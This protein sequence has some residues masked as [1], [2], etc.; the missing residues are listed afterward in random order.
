MGLFD[1]IT[2]NDLRRIA[3]LVAPIIKSD[4]IQVN[5]LPVAESIDGLYTLPAVEQKGGIIR[6]V[7]APVSLL[8]GKN[9]DKGDSLEFVILGNYP[10][11]S[12]L[13]S[14]YPNGPDRNGL[15]KVGDT[16]YT[17]TGDK[18]EPLNIDVLRTFSLE[19]F[20]EVLPVDGHI[21]IDHAKTPYAKVTL[22]G[23]N[24]IF[25]LSVNNTKDG[26]TGK[27]LVFQTGFKQISLPEGIRGTVDLPL[28]ADTIALLTYN[29]LGDT[30]YIHSNTVLGDVQFPTPQRIEDFQ[31]VYYDNSVCVLQWSAPWANNI[32]DKAT[33][34][35]MRYSNTP[36]DADDPIVWAGMKKVTGLP[37]P[38]SYPQ[39]QR[40][41]LT[42]LDAGNEYY[43]YL[44]SIKVNY[45]IRYT[46]VASDPA[47]CRTRGVDADE[48]GYYRID[49]DARMLSPRTHDT[50][51]DGSGNP[52]LI[53]NAVDEKGKD[54]FLYTGYPD[55][56]NRSYSTKW[57]LQF[58]NNFNPYRLVIDLHVPCLLDK[59]YL[60]AIGGS[61]GTFRIFVAPEIGE[62]AEYAATVDSQHNRCAVAD[63]S[64]KTGR[65]ILLQYDNDYF[66]INQDDVTEGGEFIPTQAIGNNIGFISRLMVYG[67][68]TTDK[69]A[70]LLPPVRHRLERRTVDDFFNVVGWFY[71]QGR[72]MSLC[73]GKHV[74]LFGSIGHFLPNLT[75]NPV[76]RVADVAIRANQVPWVSG[77]NGT[78]ENFIPHLHHTYERYGLKPFIA[79][80]GWPDMLFYKNADGSRQSVKPLDAYWLP[81]SWRPLPSKGLRGYERYFAQTMNPDNYKTVTKLYH[82]LAA[83]FGHGQSDLSDLKIFP[84]NDPEVSVNLDLLSG[85]EP[86][87]EEDG[88]WKGWLT[89]AQPQELAAWL[90]AVYDGH[91]GTIMD[92]EGNPIPGI[93]GVSPQTLVIV[94]GMAQINPGYFKEMYLWA[95]ENRPDGKFPAD[96][97]NVHTYFSDK[98]KPGHLVQDPCKAVT[99]EEILTWKGAMGDGLSQIVDFRNR[100]L[101]DLEIWITEFGY[102]ESGGEN[103]QSQYQCY[104]Q[105][106]RYIGS[107]L[108]PDRH[109]S[110]V[111]GAWIL[112]AALTMMRMGIGSCNCYAIEMDSYFGNGQY[113]GGAGFEMFRWNDCTDQAPG[114]KVEAIKKYMHGYDRGGFATTGIFNSLLWCGGYPITRS[115]WYIATFRNRLKGYVY[116][117]Q[118]Y[119]DTDSRIIVMCFRKKG[120]DKGAYVIYLNDDQNTGVPNVKV[121]LPD[122]SSSVTRVTTYCPEIPNPEN[123][124]ANLEFDEPRTGFPTTRRERYVNGK[125]VIQ[126]SK[127]GNTYESFAQGPADYP[128]NPQEGDEVYVLPTPEENPYFPICGP[129]GANVTKH[130]LKPSAQEYEW[131][132]PADPELPNGEPKWGM[133]GN[134][135]LAWRQVNAVCDYIEYTGE[136]R[137]GTSG[138][139]TVMELTGNA[140]IDNVTEFPA[141]YFFD[142]I[143]EPDYRSRVTDVKAVTI[144]A[145]TVK[146]FWNNGNGEDTAYEI[147]SSKSES[148]GYSLLKTV[149][150]G[151][152]NVAVLSGLDADTGYYFKIRAVSGSRQGALSDSA[153]ARTYPLIATPENLRSE[154]RTATTITLSWDY[155]AGA[156]AD[157]VMFALYRSG[158]DGSYTLVGK[159]EDLAARVFT[160]TGLLPGVSYTY[161]MRV[162]ALNGTSE[163]TPELLVTTLTAEQSAPVVSDIHTD[164]LG[165][166]IT[167]T[168]DLPM[169]AADASVKDAFTLSE[170][171]APRLVRNLLSDPE[172]PKNIILYINQD[173]LSDYDR[174][175]DIRLSYARPDT[176]ALT[177]IYGVALEPFSLRVANNIG[178]FTNLQAT[179][180]LNLCDSNSPAPLDEYWNNFIAVISENTSP[181]RDKMP[182]LKDTY[183]RTLPVAVESINEGIYKWGGT[184]NSNGTCTLPDVEEAVYK[185]SWALDYSALVT[186]NIVS[187][188]KFS[189]LNPEHKYTFRVFGSFN[190]YNDTQADQPAR[191]KING[192]Y[193]NT[194]ETANN[195]SSFMVIEDAVPDAAG[196]LNVDFL[197]LREERGGNTYFNF[198]YI[199]EYASSSEPANKDVWLRAVT[200][201]AYPD[202]VVT[203]ADIE[204]YL[205][206][207]GLATHYRVGEGAQEE[208]ES[209]AWEEIP[210]TGTMLVPY[211]LTGNFGDRVLN[212]QVK[213]DLYESN[214]RD[215]SITY[216]DPYVPLVLKNIYVNEDAAKTYSRSVQVFIERDG[217]PTHYRAG[218]TS[219]LSGVNWITW[220]ADNPASVPYTLSDGAGQKTVYLQVK[221]HL[222]ESATKVDTIDYVILQYD[223]VTLD[224]TLPAGTDTSQLAVAFAPLK[225]NKRFAYGVTSD[226]THVSAWSIL[227][228]YFNGQWI[229]NTEY[230]HMY[231]VNGNLNP[232][233]TGEYAPRALT[234]TD[235]CGM[236]RRFTIN[237]SNWYNL[238]TNN[239]DNAGGTKYPYL[240]WPEIEEM[241]DFD[242]GMSIHDVR[243]P[244]FD[245]TEPDHTGGTVENIIN[246]VAA[247]NRYV[248][249]RIGRNLMVITQPGNDSTY[250]TAGEMLDGIRMITSGQL[251]F[252]NLRN[253]SLNVNKIKCGRYFLEKASLDTYK[254][255][256]LKTLGNIG[257]G[258]YG[259]FGCH[260]VDRNK[261]VAESSKTWPAVSGFFDWLC[262]TYG[263]SGTDDMWF[264]TCEEVAQYKGLCAV[265]A[266]EH[267][268]VGDRLRINL[269]IPKLEDFNWNELTLLVSGLSSGNVTESSNVQGLSYGF[270]NDYFMINVN[271]DMTLSARAEKYVTKF[272]NEPIAVNK[273]DAEY[274]IQR[275]KPALRAPF[276]ERIAAVTAPPVLTSFVINNGAEET[277]SDVV[278]C[279]FSRP[280][281]ATH[282]MISESSV[283]AGAGWQELTGSSVSFNLSRTFGE[284]TVY[285][286]VKNAFGESN[287]LNDTIRFAPPALVLNS[288]FI[289]NGASTTTD[290]NVTVAFDYTGIATHYRIGTSADLSGVNWTTYGEGTVPYALDD[291][292]F[293][294]KTLYA[295]LRSISGDASAVISASIS[296]K[297]PNAVKLVVSFSADRKNPYP[298]DA[299]YPTVN[300]EIINYI[301]SNRYAGYDNTPLKDTSGG[302]VGYYIAKHLYPD[303]GITYQQGVNEFAGATADGVYPAIYY[304]KCLTSQRI[305]TPDSRVMFR[306][307]GLP[308][309]SY[310]VRILASTSGGNE[311]TQ[312]NWDK[313]FYI[314]NGVIQT[315]GYDPANNTSQF[316]EIS[317]VVVPADGSLDIEYYNTIPAN[318]RPCLNLVEIIKG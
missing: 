172:N 242:G 163:Y 196:E 263:E 153:F 51:V 224:V 24:R 14:A 159:V 61:T 237:T 77:N 285:F 191:I 192:T 314:A 53:D 169:S 309:G 194:V 8:K 265:T 248:K 170:D 80:S 124:P 295:Q 307:T 102:G 199:E 277:E 83:V 236:V 148:A 266:I 3:A 86:G 84:S 188:L 164:K 37:A 88:T 152:E 225:Y 215:I 213:N 212:I 157:F 120:E 226:D 254:S 121:P 119:L 55:I 64:G 297:D 136:G 289:N 34:Y 9:G 1:D 59:L 115:F 310:R 195:G 222:T 117:G 304:K 246:G 206:C 279:T 228:K 25:N 38:E 305:N 291:T 150:A 278:T 39:E 260:G 135:A 186:E 315:L 301:A 143:P 231:D 78:G 262:D 7:S 272:E 275:L 178:N 233:I 176:H 316:V 318:Y 144:N 293:G 171:D 287:V 317:G 63:L 238:N 241:L 68:K 43:I 47:Y 112:R 16:L 173:T 177:S 141:Y 252:T 12:A 156:L 95:K 232:H 207:I 210:D 154:G 179:F 123:L 127:F 105:P 66:G 145:G 21:M 129:V 181:V 282:Y 76:R 142:G 218:E 174:K 184:S 15:F 201:P 306:F 140:F 98:W 269:R 110:E 160:D 294:S 85:Q 101:P 209:V 62:S 284:H 268:V 29:R 45:G 250:I 167:V 193:S 107:W 267:F 97:L 204:L 81:E 182:A 11:L 122:G 75:E 70:S 264:A 175:T 220:P 17:W 108:I 211:H 23:D 128:E 249:A 219:D 198:M 48:E 40:F 288:I 168:F 312:A 302:L 276:A 93:K 259:E 270:K 46:S 151:V 19:Q 244:A 303:N 26:S 49:L 20:T 106:G 298:S 28:N 155:P 185:S 189:G 44:K 137:H 256:F 138:D 32:Y 103:T 255:D 4:A 42:G 146:I 221:D 223:D 283:F 57:Q 257:D 35:D 2:D 258:M 100:Y 60:Y 10:T 125:W 251:E 149:D 114:A 280:A 245:N 104:S 296:L 200:I 82:H 165:S 72:I 239:F 234:Y 56:N 54:V 286:K 253:E 109:R 158:V 67:R 261:N 74:R 274:F 133:K 240:L 99:L 273:A 6:T 300:G 18:F 71:Q 271:M 202:G 22:S 30:V 33:E 73:S 235:G 90:S 139:E 87:N 161:R 214:I 208:L 5:R 311:V 203:D 31:T 13:Q 134:V 41:S 166:K 313:C 36:V 180:K 126:N 187:R 131:I 58:N 94:P 147:F 116:T 292:S 229:D 130:L 113:E 205:N 299:N 216:R 243:D 27:I 183:G 69:P 118:K 281:H 92:E 308:Q 91:C 79:S 96:V 111:K 230:F 132:D 190:K 50:V 290:K 52:C 162:F 197:T 65:L 217:R 89:I 227:F 247:A